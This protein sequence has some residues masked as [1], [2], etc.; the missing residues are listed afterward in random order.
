MGRAGRAE[1]DTVI[2]DLLKHPYRFEFFQAVTMLR[3]EI[4]AGDEGPR[5]QAAPVGRMRFTAT[6]S[7]GFPACDITGVVASDDPD[8]RRRFEIEVPFLGLY[9]PSSPLPAFVTEH[10]IARDRDNDSMRDFLDVFNHRAVELLYS[11][12]RKY[13]HSATYQTGATDPISRYVI[14]LTGLLS[15]TS[16]ES[17]LSLESLLPFAGPLAVAGHS[18]ALLSTLV[19]HQFDGVPA[20]VEE[21]V[22]RRA[23]VDDAQ[24]NRLGVGNSTLG[25]D[26]VLGG[27][28]PDLTGKFR[29]WIGPVGIE[30]YRAFLPGL[31]DRRR[32]SDLIDAT[33]RARLDYEVVLIVRDE[34]VPPWRL[35]QSGALGHDAWLTH[36]ETVENT[37]VSAA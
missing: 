5:S 17:S 31:P 23:T 34:E 30:R 3:L 11:I 14:A 2:E 10:V 21:F 20:R 19:S 18:A 36:G 24:K 9:G 26:W 12:W 22:P 29:L 8:G 4:G 27:S 32:L 16:A 13:R 6:P 28:V 1:P 37:I 7:L 35:G 33:V 25:D 15:L